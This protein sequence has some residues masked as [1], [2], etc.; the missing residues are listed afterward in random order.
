MVQTHRGF[1]KTYEMLGTL[2]N[3]IGVLQ[4][5]T[6]VIGVGVAASVVLSAINLHQTLKLREDVKQ[7]KLEVEE[8]F[9]DLKKALK[10]QG[11][12][13]TQRIDEVAR[14]V[15]F[16]QHRLVL[17]RAYGKFLEASRRIK[18]AM[19]C[20]DVS[21]RNADLAN[22][23]QTLSE[24]L[25]DYNNPHLL[26]ELSAAGQLRR[27]ECAWAIELTIALTY[28]L[29]NQLSAVSHQ[30]SHLQDKIRQDSLTVIDRCQSED[31]LDFLFPE[32]LR[33]QTH[34]IAVLESWQH[35]VD[36]MRELAPAELKQL[37]EADL[38]D[39]D[40]TDTPETTETTPADLVPPEQTF[41]EDLKQKS[42]YLSLRDQLKFAVKPDLRQG[43]ESYIGERA[44]ATGYKGLV[45]SNWQD[46]T[47]LTLANLY[48]Y[49]KAKDESEAAV[50]S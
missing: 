39:A 19:S 20:D 33:I 7:L 31:E 5:T 48:W 41:Y 27:M 29:Q 34:D 22:A 10:N 16:E 9:I 4:A 45:P 26:S 30:L 8:G 40:V 18:F 11:A 38:D 14:D 36:W 24:A 13:I 43:H 37:Q 44:T 23:R 42:H 12:E 47:N 49:F 15:K 46:V 32:I 35:H 25:A 17:V 3:S 28:Q 6:A 21:I 1:Q 50:L 2:Q